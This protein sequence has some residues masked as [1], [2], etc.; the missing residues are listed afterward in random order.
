MRITRG[1]MLENFAKCFDIPVDEV[2]SWASSYVNHPDDFDCETEPTEKER[3]ASIKMY[4]TWRLDNSSNSRIK[5]MIADDK[6]NV[7][8]ELAGQA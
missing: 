3:F 6:R 1:T 8:I 2:V 5:A 4:I 7:S